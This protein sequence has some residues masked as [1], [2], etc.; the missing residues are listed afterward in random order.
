[1]SGIGNTATGGITNTGNPGVDGLLTGRAWVGA[2]TYSFP[3]DNTEYDPTYQNDTPFSD[4]AALSAAQQAAFFFAL[5]TDMGTA[6]EAG[7]SVEGFTNL[8]ISLTTDTQA[9]IRGA[10][11]SVP[12]TAFAYYPGTGYDEAGDI[13]FGTAFD[14]TNPIM[15]S[16]SFLTHIHEIGHALGLEHGHSGVNTIPIETD[17]LAYSVMTYRAYEDASTLTGYGAESFGYP[18]TWMMF[19]IAAL[20]HMYGADYTTQD[21]D[22]TYTWSTTTGETF[23]DGVS[24]LAPGG[25]RIFAT[26]WDGGGVD[27]YDLSNY[28]TDLVI[29]LQPGSYSTF[30][31]AQLANLGGGNFADGNIYNAM[32]HQGNTASLIENAEGGTGDDLIIA[33]A[34]DNVLDGNGGTNT[35]SYAGDAAGVTIDLASGTATG[36]GTGSDTLLNFINAAGG[37]GADT[38]TGTAGVNVL[39]G[40]LGADYIIGGNGSDIL[41][42]GMAGENLPSTISGIGMGSGQYTRMSDAGNDSIANAIDISGRFSLAADAD[43]ANATTIPHVSIEATGD[44][45]LSVHYYAVTISYVGTRIILD[46]DYGDTNG[47]A[48]GDMDSWIE[49][50]DASGTRV[51]FD[52]DSGI[53]QGDG[54]SVANNG[55]TSGTTDSYVSYTTL[56][57]GTF[58]IA[59]GTFSN[60]SAVPSGGTYELQ[61]SVDESV[62]DMGDD[63]N[64]TLLGGIGADTLYGGD[65]NDILEGGSGADILNGGE[66]MDFA[67]YAASTNR[68]TISLITDSAAGSHAIGDSFISIENLTGSNFGDT[69]TGGNGRNDIYGGNGRDIMNGFKGDDFLYGEAGNDFMTGGQ[70]ADYIDGGTGVDI[71]R[72]AGSNAGVQIDLDAG[73]ATG[74]YAQGDTLVNI[75]RLFGSN[76]GDTLRGDDGN[77]WIFGHNGDDIVSGGSGIDRLYGGNGQ[78]TFD[79]NVGDK[80]AYVMDFTNDVDTIDLSDFGYATLGDALAQMSQLGNNVRFTDGNGNGMLI[81]NTDLND[82]MDDISI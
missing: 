14:F 8:D 24:A 79:F 53:D 67:S 63:S 52:D 7:F 15:G 76:H 29:D 62:I 18:Q 75:E 60:L 6:A 38:I 57:T 48:A 27:T 25:N 30:G 36:T 73:T 5:D 72:Y 11:S 43:I 40:G 22:T 28:T 37:D 16:Y 61:I 82:I 47:A 49:L 70:G 64:D 34:A 44:A 50:Y 71:A 51:S 58:Y 54:G 42:G 12:G 26:I 19:D 45:A 56:T 66:G 2:I 32:L 33:N 3:G 81:L 78:D 10:T 17:Q 80:F 4:F 46:L 21:G 59:V 23:I 41:Y 65:G 77:N 13:W 69:L 55:S 35:V 68:V 9:N 31:T 39:E 1:M 20:Q 74:G